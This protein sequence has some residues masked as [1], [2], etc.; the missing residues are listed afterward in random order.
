MSDPASAAFDSRSLATL[1]QQLHDGPL[2]ELTELHRKTALLSTDAA[3]DRHERLQ[4]LTELALVSLSAMEHFHAFTR[5]LRAQ[6]AALAAAP[7]RDL[8]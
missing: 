7:A 5:E 1:A 4:R 6:I 8:H 3:V 2:Q